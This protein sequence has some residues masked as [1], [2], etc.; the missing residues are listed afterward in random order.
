MASLTVVFAA[1]GQ[2][3]RVQDASMWSGVGLSGSL[4]CSGR[5]VNTGALAVA[6]P[7]PAWAP[8][9]ALLHVSSKT[10]SHGGKHSA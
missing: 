8:P 1:W 4:H 10:A 6:W 9:R 3:A 7:H 2:A 5:P